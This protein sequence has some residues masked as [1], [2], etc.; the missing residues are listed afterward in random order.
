MRSAERL[1]TAAVLS[2]ALWLAA[3]ATPGSKPEAP[4]GPNAPAS[5]AAP[6]VAPEPAP[7]T[8]AVQRAYD[9]ARAAMAAGQTAE[10]ERALVAL[11]KS[12]PELAGPWA[13]LGI[14]YRNAGKTADAVAALEKA[15]KL[16]PANAEIANQLGVAYRMAGQFK[17]A[18]ASYERSITLDPAYAAAVLNLGILY[19]LYLW[20]GARAL[21]L[22]DRYLLMAPGD[23]QVQRWVAD[24][25]N[26]AGKSAAVPR[27]EPG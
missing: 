10:A 1:R 12:H 26:R 25:K 9:G 19:D 27:K 17:Q 23:A 18:K 6:A 24:L 2:A 16:A 7:V 21:E 5:S 22:Y 8:P 15:A 14:L 3:C 13:N 11:T 20:D 4:G